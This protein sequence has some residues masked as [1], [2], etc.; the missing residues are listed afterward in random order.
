[1]SRRRLLSLILAGLCITAAVVLLALALDVRRWQHGLT[2]GDVRFHETP[3]PQSLWNASELVP[4]GAARRLL[5]VDDDL[6]FRRVV[7]LFVLGRVH[8]SAFTEP[9]LAAIRGKAQEQL[10][11]IAERD[12]EPLRRAAAHDLLGV[13]A[14]ATVPLDDLLRQTLLGNAVAELQNAVELDPGYS[15]AKYNLELALTRLRVLEQSPSSRLRRGSQ[16]SNRQKGAG[17]LDAGS[18]Y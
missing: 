2:A 14:L 1:M 11:R 16:S 13:L 12:P 10:G 7:R 9:R 17:A 3:P 6:A 18:G 15:E 4:G 8:D 5:G